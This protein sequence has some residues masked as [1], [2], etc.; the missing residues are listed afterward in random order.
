[1]VPGKPIQLT[2]IGAARRPQ[3]PVRAPAV[4]HLTATARLPFPRGLENGRDLVRCTEPRPWQGLCPGLGTAELGRGAPPRP[5]AA[6]PVGQSCFLP[7]EIPPIAALQPALQEIS[8]RIFVI[9]IG[10]Q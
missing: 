8:P 5:A 10:R 1:M 3:I 9:R 7:L 6:E 4:T 2:R